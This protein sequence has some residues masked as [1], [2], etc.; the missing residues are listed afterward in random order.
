[1]LPRQPTVLFRV[2]FLYFHVPCYFNTRNGIA[3][4]K[5]AYPLREYEKTRNADRSALRVL[6]EAG[7]VEPPSENDSTGTSPG[8]DDF[9]HSL[10]QA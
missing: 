7:G 4:L 3:E 6:V 2:H 5:T 1:M 8:A 9:L 10:A